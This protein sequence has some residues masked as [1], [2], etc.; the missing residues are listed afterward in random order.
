MEKEFKRG[1]SLKHD[2][3]K[4]GEVY[5][6]DY[7]LLKLSGEPIVYTLHIRSMLSNHK[8]YIEFMVTGSFCVCAQEVFTNSLLPRLSEI[9]EGGI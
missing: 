1:C 4:S 6:P 9:K 5:Y 7:V 8:V 2:M 3:W